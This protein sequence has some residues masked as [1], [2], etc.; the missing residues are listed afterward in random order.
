ME[1]TF[2]EE[3]PDRYGK[4][5]TLLVTYEE[6]EKASSKEI[7]NFVDGMKILLGTVLPYQSNTSE[8]ILFHF[9]GCKTPENLKR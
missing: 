8:G 4:K 7:D 6:I 1:Y 2:H 5:I 3:K 9:S